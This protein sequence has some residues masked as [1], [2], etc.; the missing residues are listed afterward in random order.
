MFYYTKLNKKK[1]LQKNNDGSTVKSV[2]SVL[3]HK[4]SASLDKLFSYKR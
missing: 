1:T 2:Y 3:I 4:K